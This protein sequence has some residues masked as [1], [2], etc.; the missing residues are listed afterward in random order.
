LEIGVGEKLT[1]LRVLLL[2]LIVLVLIVGGKNGFKAVISFG[3]N[4]CL[5]FLSVILIAGGFS[6][7]IVALFSGCCIL[8]ITIYLSDCPEKV[9]NTA[10]LATIIVLGL[11]IFLLIPLNSLTQIEGFSS[12][13]SEE[14]EAF[15]LAIGVNFESLLTATMLLSTLGA[16]AEAAIAIT[17]GMEEILLQTPEI[18]KNELQKSGRTI[19]FQIMG[20]TFNTLFFGM[21]GGNLALFILL[22]KLQSSFSYYLNSKIFVG[23]TFSVLYSAIAVIAVI[24]TAI[25][26]MVKKSKLTK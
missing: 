3:L 5:L 24:G 15:N 10:F 20:M 25:E 12:E 9:A 8:A 2:L 13:D 18:S 16:I 26:L 21:F 1:T 6:A 17:S 22:D 4:F 14:I 7:I 23:E 11:M 19:G